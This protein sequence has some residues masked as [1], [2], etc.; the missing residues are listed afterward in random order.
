MTAA[1]RGSVA[2]S[3]GLSWARSMP[4]RR[5]SFILVPICPRDLSDAAPPRQQS[6]AGMGFSLEK[7]LPSL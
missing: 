1:E 4:M 6:E 2:A 7:D 5:Q 3:D